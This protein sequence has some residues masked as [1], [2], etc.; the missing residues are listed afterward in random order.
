MADKAKAVALSEYQ[1][2]PYT[3]DSIDLSID[4]G[5]SLTQVRARLVCRRCVTD[6][7]AP[8]V[9][10]GLNLRLLEISIDQQAL[11]PEDY[12]L[13]ANHL[14][15]L[16]VPDEF[17]LETIVEIS[18][19]ANLALSGLYMS[20]GNYCTQ[21]ESEG[22]R[23]ITY[24]LDRPDVM[25]VYTC[26]ISAEHDET[27]VILSN[28]NRVDSGDL[29][30]GRHWVK[31]HDPSKKP[32]YLF[33][34]VAGRF[35][36]LNST[37]TTQ[38]G[39]DIRL[40]VYVEPSKQGQARFALEALKKAML[41]DE[42]VYQREYELDCYMI[43]AVSDFNFGAME[44]K[45]LNI[46]NDRYV[47]AKTE[48]AT[49]ADF[50]GVEIV[51]GHEYFHNWTGNRITL[52]NW[53][54]LCLKEGLTVFREQGFS[55]K[56]SSSG[57]RRIQEAK[58]I[59]IAQF[60]ED[61]GPMAHPVRPNA[62]LE[63]SN[64]YTLT[65]YNKG[66]EVIR[67][68]QTWLGEV[69]FKAGMQIY[70]KQYDGQAITIDEFLNAMA[71][72][73]GQSM[74]QFKFWYTEQGTPIVHLETKYDADL[75]QL[76]IIA[77]QSAP[78]SN[79]SMPAML[80]PIRVGFLDQS[81]EALQVTNAQNVLQSE[82]ILLL[83]QSQQK[84]IF[85]DVEAEPICSLLREFS[86]PIRL[87]YALPR[88][89]ALCLIENDTDAYVRWF[90]L[91]QLFFK[92]VKACLDADG[93]VLPLEDDLLQV[94][95]NIL[96]NTEKCRAEQVEV[97]SFPSE[98]YLL[99]QF[100]GT[101]IHR[102]YE[103][104]QGVLKQ[105]AIHLYDIFETVY[106]SC[107][108]SVPYH[109]SLNDVSTRALRNFCLM[110]LIY[111]GDAKADL[112]CKKQLEE[113]D[114]MTDMMGA[115]SAVVHSNNIDL[116][117]SVLDQFYQTWQH[118]PLVIDK[119]LSCQAVSTS[120]DVLQ[121]VKALCQ[122]EAFDLYNPNRVRALIGMFTSNN[123]VG[124]HASNGEGYEFLANKIIKIEQ[125][126]PHLAARLCQPLLH[127]RRFDLTRQSLMKVQLERIAE[128]Q[129]LSLDVNEIV[130][131]ALAVPVD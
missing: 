73:S 49:D 43:V 25:S 64:F 127:W 19:S 45:G 9:L 116:R 7:E 11:M 102:L 101:D 92:H 84:F 13:D 105:C 78:S 100:P 34:L 128:I 67:M 122:H 18:P 81:G 129:N 131:R 79:V 107:K 99:E 126:N 10:D 32:C 52:R 12:R 3:I 50:L 38:S 123:I 35:D 124:F 21:C 80:I 55:A 5:E 48:T 28:G 72:S 8:M 112:L 103:I 108:T 61:S 54:Q 113:S 75:K 66:A 88:S 65:V 119:W 85:S 130:G 76:S 37:Y 118:E 58:V 59:Q 77:R 70:F 14:T 6:A 40:E 109:Y 23:C 93:R 104:R 86:A 71:E 20:S 114:N 16:N 115:I 121:H 97:L 44:N 117:A 69:A 1:P 31:W 22:F 95:S 57:V 26:T 2:P 90:T 125:F 110:N 120:A 4:L 63:I 42:E 24:Y 111:A 82:T 106:H 56:I 60:L 39:R 68:L 27:P 91:N 30:G 15:L 53:F 36:V 87:E 41:W 51:V 17:I 98:R 96:Q 94:Y 62:Y 33:A 46:F 83:E 74:E 47:L 29:P 89:Q